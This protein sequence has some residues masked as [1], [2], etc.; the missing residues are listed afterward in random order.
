MWSRWAARWPLTRPQEK[1]NPEHLKQVMGSIESN[2]VRQLGKMDV[3]GDVIDKLEARL[4]AR[5][6]T[7]LDQMRAEWIK[8]KAQTGEGGG[9]AK[10]HKVLSVLQTL[11]QSV[12][13]HDELGAIL[14]IVRN[15]VEP[16]KSM[17][18]TIKRSR[19]R[20][21]ARNDWPRRERPTGSCPPG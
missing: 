7:V 17:K 13:E 18:T 8:T 21:P 5:M 20:F 15:K 19:T 12:S 14:K 3:G 16:V 11:E 6:E 4:N 2:I 10:P 9:P 1:D